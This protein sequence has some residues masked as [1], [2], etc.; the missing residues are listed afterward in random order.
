MSFTNIGIEQ[1]ELFWLGDNYQSPGEKGLR[2]RGF[3]LIDSNGLPKS[4]FETNDPIHVQ[5]IYEFTRPI[6]GARM[7]LY[8]MTELGGIAFLVTDD[9]IRVNSYP[10][11][12]YRSALQREEFLTLTIGG[13][14]NQGSTSRKA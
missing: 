3:R 14:R 8:V 11:G 4:T 12:M 6:R 7:N 9:I 10:V 13:E 2:L 5:I 1:N